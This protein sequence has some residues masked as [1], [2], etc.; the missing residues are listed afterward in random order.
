MAILDVYWRMPDFDIEEQVK[1][2]RRVTH[3]GWLSDEHDD[4]TRSEPVLVE[5][6]SERVFRPGELPPDTTL[7][8]EDHPGPM[9]PLAEQARRAGF[10]IEHALNDPGLAD[11]PRQTRTDN[12]AEESGEQRRERF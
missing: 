7:F 6:R 12:D 3:T 11:R 2:E 8:I 4:A 5:Q 10:V 1:R 9:S